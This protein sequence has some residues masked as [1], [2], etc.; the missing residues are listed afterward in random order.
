MQMIMNENSKYPRLQISLL[1]RVAELSFLRALRGTYPN[2]T[3]A[4]ELVMR[5][6]RLEGDM[7]QTEL[8]SRVGQDRNN[9]SRTLGIL[10]KKG[11]ISKKTQEND[12]RFSLVSITSE[13]KKVHQDIFMIMEEWRKN[14]F[15]KGIEPSELV[16]FNKTFMKLVKNLQESLVKK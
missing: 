4:Q 13:G 9:L 10:K 15:F 1:Y 12:R 11:L 14:V 2:I 7:N 5:V 6:L 8:A 3:G 16:E